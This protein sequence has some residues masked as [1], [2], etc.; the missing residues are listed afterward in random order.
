MPREVRIKMKK[1]IF[2]IAIAVLLLVGFT[3]CQ[4]PMTYKVPT[5]LVATA[6]NKDYIVDDGGIDADP[7]RLELLTLRHERR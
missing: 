1:S 6:P 3:A 5:A 2:Y 7:P 4:Q